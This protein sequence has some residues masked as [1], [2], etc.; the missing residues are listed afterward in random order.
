MILCLHVRHR[1]TDDGRDDKPGF[2]GKRDGYILSRHIARNPLKRLDSD[3]RIQENP[4][5]WKAEFRRI[6]RKSV[7]FRANPRKSKRLGKLGGFAVAA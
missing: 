7:E 2:A 6:P 4:R 3:E 1:I 5:I